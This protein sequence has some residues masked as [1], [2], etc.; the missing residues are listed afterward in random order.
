MTRFR[1]P[2]SANNRLLARIAPEL[3]ALTAIGPQVRTEA[4][5]IAEK[6]AAP[7]PRDGKPCPEAADCP[8]RRICA[9]EAAR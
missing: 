3:R 9:S 7:C 6:Y 8:F 1:Q 5:R 4:E 2:T